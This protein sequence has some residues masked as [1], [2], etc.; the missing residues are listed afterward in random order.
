MGVA[1]SHFPQS[2]RTASPAR[3]P[4][5]CHSPACLAGVVGQSPGKQI[6]QGIALGY[7]AVDSKV[8]GDRQEAT[9]SLRLLGGDDHDTLGSLLGILGVLDVVGVLLVLDDFHGSNLW[10]RQSLDARIGHRLAIEHKQR[11]LA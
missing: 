4:V 10:R 11:D 5:R 9:S 3:S 7:D 2:A 6:G 1:S 8:A